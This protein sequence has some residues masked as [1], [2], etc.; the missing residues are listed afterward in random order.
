MIRLLTII[1]IFC[2][3]PIE[4]GRTVGSNRQASRQALA[5]FSGNNNEMLGFAAFENGFIFKNFS[6]RCDFNSFYP[7]SGPIT[8]NDGELNL[9]LPLILGDTATL[10]TG[11]TFVGN[12]L[13]IEFPN[14]AGTFSLGGATTFE[15]IKIVLN[16]DLALNSVATFVGSCILEGNNK[17]IDFAS[18]TISVESG[19]TLIIRNARLKNTVYTSISSPDAT[20][21]L[22]LENVVWEQPYSTYV[23]PGQA[24][25]IPSSEDGGDYIF[26]P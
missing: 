9:I 17:V 24:T 6:T 20:G 3:L 16:S 7:V 11:G 10:V 2:A 1:L 23:F 18:G 8:M 14:I 22:I 21:V 4:A 25:S 26:R 13:S 15:S 12:N 19:A 5:E